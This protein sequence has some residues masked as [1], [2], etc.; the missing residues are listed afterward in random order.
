MS[1][2]GLLGLVL[3]GLLTPRYIILQSLIIL[4]CL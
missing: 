4:Q 1:F 3:G 2:S